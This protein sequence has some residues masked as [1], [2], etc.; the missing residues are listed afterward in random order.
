MND[1]PKKAI[2]LLIDAD[3]SPAAK[4]EFIIT[5]LA[6]YGTVNIRRAYGNWK[7]RG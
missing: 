5:E 4:I 1:S 3:N 7:K 2:A 6:S